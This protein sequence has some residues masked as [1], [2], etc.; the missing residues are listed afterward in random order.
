MLSGGHRTLAKFCQQLISSCEEVLIDFATC[1]EES[2]S[3][4]DPV[5]SVLVASLSPLRSSELL[6]ISLRLSVSSIGI[7]RRLYE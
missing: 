2:G 7:S 5:S 1:V 6:L 3:A 4:G